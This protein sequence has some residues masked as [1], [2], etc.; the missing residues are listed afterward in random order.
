MARP[1]LLIR[2]IQPLSTVTPNG[3]QA[4]R[5][6]ET[7]RVDPVHEPRHRG[8]ERGPL[9]RGGRHHHRRDVVK[10]PQRG[11]R[12]QRVDQ[13][14][15]SCLACTSS[16]TS[17]AWAPSAIT[18]RLANRSRNPREDR[19]GA[20]SGHSLLLSGSGAGTPPR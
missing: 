3:Q 14:P 18:V 8:V 2:P 4:E 7:H 5:G 13:Q 10:G 20:R 9:E 17:L 19:H 16:A 15:V 6:G 12:Q 1:C 11:G